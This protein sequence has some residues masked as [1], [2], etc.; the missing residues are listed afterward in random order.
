[1]VSCVGG[2]VRALACQRWRPAPA[3]WGR[4]GMRDVCY[5]LVMVVFFLLMHIYVAW[6][7]RLGRGGTS[8]EGR[9]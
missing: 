7:K 4:H 3:V 6:C 1:M 8:D 2:L 5:F 9:R